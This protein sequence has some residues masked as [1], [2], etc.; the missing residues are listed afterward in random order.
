MRVCDKCKNIT[1]SSYSCFISLL[2]Q[3]QKGNKDTDREVKRIPM[4]LCE[5]CIT[6][7]IPILG[8]LITNIIKIQ[9]P[10]ED[11]GNGSQHH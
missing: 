8:Q 2:K 10:E 4:D 11:T 1:K 5:E 6:A 7:M 9:K 3:E